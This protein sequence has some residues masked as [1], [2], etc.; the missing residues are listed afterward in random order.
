MTVTSYDKACSQG[1][2]ACLAICPNTAGS[3]LKY[4]KYEYNGK[5]KEK[6]INKEEN[7]ISLSDAI[8]GTVKV[9][10]VDAYNNQSNLHRFVQSLSPYGSLKYIFKSNFSQS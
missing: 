8:N 2:T 1:D 9:K 10:T 3:G 6:E 5:Q 7:K 4:L